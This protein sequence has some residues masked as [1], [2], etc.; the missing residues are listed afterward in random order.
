ML[1]KR[2]IE[3]FKAIVKGGFNANNNETSLEISELKRKSYDM[4][5]STEI[6][7]SVF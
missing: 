7:R 1:S 5:F 4:I 2:E 6:V 3:T